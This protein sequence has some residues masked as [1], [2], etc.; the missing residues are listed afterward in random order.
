MS[1]PRGDKL[2]WIYS[3]GKAAHRE[4]Y[5]PHAA[6][7]LVSFRH[8]KPYSEARFEKDIARTEWVSTVR[9]V[10][11]KTFAEKFFRPCRFS[12]S[13]KGI[14]FFR[15]RIVRTFSCSSNLNSIWK[16][17]ETVSWCLENST[18]GRRISLLS[19]SVAITRTNLVRF[20]HVKRALFRRTRFS[21]AF[22]VEWRERGT[23]NQRR[24]GIFSS[25][26]LPRGENRAIN[27]ANVKVVARTKRGNGISLLSTAVAITRANSY[28]RAI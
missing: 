7:Y 14:P 16:E 10:F 5:S 28:R 22:P 1:L 24:A 21:D 17:R 15:I 4:Y 6:C 23:K 25:E 2:G 27:I 3:G 8:G 13:P 26:F 20:L 11:P 12:N 9:F 18:G 19:T